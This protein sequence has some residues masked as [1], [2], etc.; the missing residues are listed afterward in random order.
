MFKLNLTQKIFITCLIYTIIFLATSSN[1][2]NCQFGDSKCDDRKD[3]IVHDSVK[4]QDDTNYLLFHVN[5]GEGY[6]L[7]RQVLVRLII[8]VNRLVKSGQKWKLVLPKMCRTPHAKNYPPEGCLWSQYIDID[9]LSQH[10]PVID[11]DEFVK[12]KGE[13]IDTVLHLKLHTQRFD[14]GFFWNEIKCPAYLN[15]DTVS[16]YM[17]CMPIKLKDPNEFHCIDTLSTTDDDFLPKYFSTKKSLSVLFLHAETLAWGGSYWSSERSDIYKYLRPSTAIEN[18]ARNYIKEHLCPDT[19]SIDDCKFIGVHMRRGDFLYAHS[20]ATPELDQIIEQIDQVSMKYGIEK[21]FIATDDPKSLVE[22]KSKLK[23]GKLVTDHVHPTSNNDLEVSMV[24]QTILAFSRVFV[25][26]LHSTFSHSVREM[27][28][29][30][31]PSH[32]STSRPTTT[33]C[34]KNEEQKFECPPLQS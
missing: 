33:L 8:V 21:I 31:Y 19:S 20:D 29:S 9:K 28:D 34:R 5:S 18:Y 14:I 24:E 10:V 22:I 7:R 30:G 23:V 3:D 2:N 4:I 6:N 11:Y 27:I 1:P 15:A 32:L 25:G 26:T 12:V 13:N 16:S 17:H